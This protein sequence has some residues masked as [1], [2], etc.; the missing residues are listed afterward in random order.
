MWR[1]LLGITLFGAIACA[2]R[3]AISVVPKDTRIGSQRPVFVATTRQSSTD[4]DYSSLRTSRLQFARYDVSIPPNHVEGHIE[5]P[6]GT[7]NPE[8][9]FVTTHITPFDTAAQFGAAVKRATQQTPSTAIVFVHGFNTTF[10]EG[11]YRAAQVAHDMKDPNASVHYSWP[12]TDK[13]LEYTRDRDSVLF[14]RDGLEQLLETLADQG[15]ANIILVAHSIGSQLTV[16]TLRQIYL[17]QKTDVM[18]RLAGVVLI[19]PDIDNTLF[20]Q[21]ISRITPLPQPFVVFGDE[22]DLAL[23]VSSFLTGRANRVGQLKR[24]ETL[25]RKGVQF[26]DVTEIDDGAGPFKHAVPIT[27]PTMLSILRNLQPADATNLRTQ[28]DD[29][30][31]QINAT[32]R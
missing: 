8:T 13:I 27:S 17:Q 1:L 20:E 31:S 25:K 5:W 15:N 24:T 14:A 26:V 32:L 7:P 4:T 29:I 23:K 3:G 21:Q 28:S 12:A 19:S 11:T 30:Q 2:D 10:A 9:D 22:K 16:E 6:T 18:K